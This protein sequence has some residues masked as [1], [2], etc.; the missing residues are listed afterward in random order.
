ME[1]ALISFNQIVTM[2][3]IMMIGLLCAKTKLIDEET[4]KKLSAFL[5]WVVSPLVIFT[6]YQRPFE[7]ELLKGLFIALGLA[8]LSF[9]ISILVAHTLYFKKDGKIETIE[10]YACIY[11]NSGFIGIPLVQG[12]FGSEGVFYL[13]AF[14]TTSNLLM[15]THGVTIMSGIKDRSLLKKAFLAPAF[16]GTITGF[17]TFLLRIEVPGILLRP[18]ETVGGTNTALAMIIA[19]VT[20]SKADIGQIVKKV[21]IYKVCLIRLLV[22]PLIVV[23]VFSFFDFPQTVVGTIAIAA[24]CPVAANVILFSYRYDKDSLYASELFVASTIF[25]LVT[26]PILMLLI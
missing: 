7:A 16:I 18:M 23:G 25:S 9:A 8:V 10:K 17:I 13:T 14:L 12:V 3:I 26:M 20:I 2:I 21:R 4:S 24:S 11:T 5:L 19:G 1:T 15:W 22:I 6:S